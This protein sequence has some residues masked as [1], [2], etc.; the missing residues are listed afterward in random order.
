MIKLSPSRNLSETKAGLIAAS[1][2]R[3]PLDTTEYFVRQQYV[4]FLNR[5]P[6]ETG[7]SFWV[8]NI[9][10]CGADAKL[11]CGKAYRHVRGVLPLD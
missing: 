8:N 3:N 6:D 11:S 5:E 2:R 4:D 10:S 1:L 7:F 9:E